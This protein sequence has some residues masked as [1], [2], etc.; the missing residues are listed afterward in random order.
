MP[1]KHTLGAGGRAA[2][3]PLLAG[4]DG[5]G[6]VGRDGGPPRGR[7][8]R[9]AQQRCRDVEAPRHRG[10]PNETPSPACSLALVR[11]TLPCGQA[12]RVDA[13]KHKSDKYLLRV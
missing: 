9:V 11:R 8:D 6:R 4:A 10:A 5:D 13:S 3:H 1:R 12:S 2:N 7:A